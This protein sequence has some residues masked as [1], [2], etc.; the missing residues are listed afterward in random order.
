MYLCLRVDL[1]YVP[2]DSPDAK[3]FGHGE[4]AVVIR[5]LDLARESGLKLHFFASERVLRAFPSGIHAVLNDG[6]H[7]DFLSKHPEEFLPRYE[8]A[9]RRFS[10]YGVE[11]M[12]FA[13]REAWPD[14]VP[15]PEFPS[16]LVFASAPIGCHL[17]RLQVF[18]V[19]TR[20]ERDALR[21]GQTVRV[22]ADG[23]R[24]KLRECVSLNRGATIMVRP[25]VL[26]KIDPKLKS[27]RELAELG[28][29]LGLKQRTLRDLVGGSA[30]SEEITVPNPD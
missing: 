19:E 6:H 29:A 7:L 12:G 4:P 27:I 10:E 3:E 26:A 22:W 20:P 25:Q 2:W 21:A 5:L 14:S 15:V 17:G 28:I 18:P 30:Q 8:S 13:L 16:N 1:D 24:A 23:V 11:P 9:S